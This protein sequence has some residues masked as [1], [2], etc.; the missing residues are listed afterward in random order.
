MSNCMQMKKVTIKAVLDQR[1]EKSDAKYPVKLRV[2]HDRKQKYYA[3]KYSMTEAD[4]L[5]TTGKRPDNMKDI[6]FE[7][8]DEEKKAIR[9]AEKINPFSWDLFE[10]KYLNKYDS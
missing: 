3:T 9:I 4:W 2:T 10:K 8:Q 6:L 5:K 1:Y 7:L